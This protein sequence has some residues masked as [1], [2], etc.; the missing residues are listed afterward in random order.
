MAGRGRSRYARGSIGLRIR[1]ASSFRYGRSSFTLKLVMLLKQRG[2]HNTTIS[3]LD[4]VALL[5]T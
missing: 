5:A 3:S 2:L 4:F 1:L